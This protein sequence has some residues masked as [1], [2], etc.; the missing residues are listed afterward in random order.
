MFPYEA[1]VLD[2]YIYAIVLKYNNN[3][4]LFLK[5]PQC[6][7][8]TPV[9]HPKREKDA[10]GKGEKK[11]RTLFCCTM[12]KCNYVHNSMKLSLKIPII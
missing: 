6:C 11:N 3:H 9:V 10:K 5:I 1:C 12:C 8:V 2:I 7:A 4:S